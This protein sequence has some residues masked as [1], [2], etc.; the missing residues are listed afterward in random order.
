[1]YVLRQ[2]LPYPRL[3]I[4]FRYRKSSSRWG[5]DRIKDGFN[6]TKEELPFMVAGDKESLDL[7]VW[8]LILILVAVVAVIVIVVMLLT[9]R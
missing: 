2:T 4:P 8:D 7:P 3:G 9:R 1:M 6:V 5:F